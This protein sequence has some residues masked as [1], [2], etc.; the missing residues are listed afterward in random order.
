MR[1][2]AW[3]IFAMQLMALGLS[4]TVIMLRLSGAPAFWFDEG[5]KANAARTLAELGIY[6]T[7]TADGL[8]PFDPGMSGGP[9]DIAPMAL[10]FRLLGVS[11]QSARLPAALYGV[12]GLI[13]LHGI[14]A[15]LHG[16]RAAL[17]VALLVL[18]APPLQGIGYT[19]LA[20][21]AVSEIPALA[22]MLFSLACLLSAGQ[23]EQHHHRRLAL[24]IAAGVLFGLSMLSRQQ[25]ALTF[26]PAL[27]VSI[28]ARLNW[29]VLRAGGWRSRL[30]LKMIA[31]EAIP[32]VVMAGMVLAWKSVEFVGAGPA[33]RAFNTE[34]ALDAARSNLITGLWG[35]ALNRSAWLIVLIQL[36]AVTAGLWRLRTQRSR[37]TAAQRQLELFMISGVAL[38]AAWFAL[39]SVGWLRYAFP[40]LFFAVVLL[41]IIAWDRAR[42]NTTLTH[43][44]RVWLGA[45]VL[46]GAAALAN[47][48]SS[49]AQLEYGAAQMGAYVRSS[50]PANAVIESWEWEISTLSQ[51][52]Q[53]HLPEQ[54]Y[55][56]EAI[57]IRSRGAA[58]IRLAYD[59]M[60]HDPDYLLLGPFE[61]L[62]QVY[63]RDT[64]ARCFEPV[65]R[66]EPY[67]LLRRSGCL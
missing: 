17:F 15:R 35:S 11:V 61:A 29:P 53:F 28:A 43:K 4:V 6:G 33:V 36:I 3:L 42:Q 24:R 48:A 66:F 47:F 18:A 52:S 13:A 5:Y 20:R 64:I 50:V 22:M 12:L 67:T 46:L 32:L 38:H 23:A 49:T 19:A 63:A 59:M 30:S 25:W 58:D 26:G 34:M 9:A 62:A 40:G 41:A 51:P 56:F 65:V 60:K 37:M 39:L 14:V 16:R 54:R 7:Q 21:Q 10:S 45:C 8:L 31:A 1:R 2:G 55:L 44:A 57:R 27:L